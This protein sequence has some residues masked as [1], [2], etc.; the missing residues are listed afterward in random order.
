[1]TYKRK[2]LKDNNIQLQKPVR[3]TNL[4]KLEYQMSEEYLIS[5]VENYTNN[6]T[7][8]PSATTTNHNFS[9]IE[10]KLIT[11][12]AGKNTLSVVPNYFVLPTF[13]YLL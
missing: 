4:K 8:Q 2:T 10:P 11:E 7:I 3:T 1:M 12:I 9:F 13:E 5:I 6:G